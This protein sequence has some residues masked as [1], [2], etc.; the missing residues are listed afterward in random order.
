M[1]YTAF[2]F[3]ELA[4]LLSA[5]DA[6]VRRDQPRG[7]ILISSHGS[8][9]IGLFPGDIDC[10]LLWVHTNV[11]RHMA[12]GQWLVGGER[13][14][15]APERAFYFENPRDFE[16]YHVPAGLDPGEYVKTGELT[17]TNTFSLLNYVNNDTYDECVSART[18]IPL[19]DPYRT[20]LDYAGVRIEDVISLPA[21]GVE[22]SVWSVAQIYTCGANAPGTVLLPAAARAVAVPYLGSVPDRR[23][24]HD[25]SGCIRLLIDGTEMYCV[26]LRPE[27]ARADNPC[28]ILYLSPAPF[29][30]RWCCLL[31]CTNDSPRLQD[32]CVD[33]S[34]ENPEGLRGAIQAF[35][36]GPGFL[37][38]EFLPFGEI[39]LQM[40]RGV[41]IDGG[42]VS[43]GTHDLLGYVGSRTEM[44]EL[45]RAVIGS[46]KVPSVF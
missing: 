18:F 35:N 44:L 23:L 10:N 5:G 20:G 43:R 24:G 27:D 29:S 31:K 14:W 4:T 7:R 21:P 17:F 33:V 12:E 3:E 30:D 13:L 41:S 15:I 34:Q 11:N 1:P 46:A 39:G 22:M 16:G 38:G 9:L 25:A 32:G 36:S 42:T 19:E 6:V 8:R 26:A 37:E 40:Q 28:K 45:A 2:T